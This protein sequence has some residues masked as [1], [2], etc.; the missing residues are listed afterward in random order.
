MEKWEVLTEYQ[1]RYIQ[2]QD[3]HYFICYLVAFLHIL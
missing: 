2:Q 1:E 3:R